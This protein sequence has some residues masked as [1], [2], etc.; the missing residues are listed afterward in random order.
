MNR[1][2]LI[3][4]T[5]PAEDSA[6]LAAMLADQGIASI[7]APVMR[8][9]LLAT[10]TIDRSADGILLTSRHAVFAIAPPLKKLP[11]YCVGEATAAAARAHGCQN[12]V[13]G[14]GEVLA[15]LPLLAKTFTRDHRLLYFSGEEVRFDLPAMAAACGLTV[16]RHVVYRTVAEEAMTEDLVTALRANRVTAVACF[17]PNTATMIVRWLVASHQP[18]AAQ[19]IDF[20]ALSLAV[21]QAAAGAPW[22][23]LHA[24]HTPQ[25]TSMVDLIVSRVKQ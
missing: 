22:Q 19:N 5:R 10:P 1:P 6:L 12:V 3:W 16:D 9:E 23:S 4:L 2:P 20:Y 15:L 21:A 8:V 25:L 17:S 24:C 18:A 14:D 11:I 7:V 13:A